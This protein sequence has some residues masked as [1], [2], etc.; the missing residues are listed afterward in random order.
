MLG[1]EKLIARCETCGKLRKVSR[2]LLIRIV[3]SVA[4][5][6]LVPVAPIV[7]EAA[8]GEVLDDLPIETKTEFRQA[9]AKIWAIRQRILVQIWPDRCADYHWW[10]VGK[11]PSARI[12]IGNNC[13]DVLPEVLS[14][15]LHSRKR[16]KSSLF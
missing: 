2:Q 13:A 12:E 1:R 9:T 14:Q 7:I 6:R 11:M 15:R 5:K 16:R 4:R 10:P 8:L 3:K